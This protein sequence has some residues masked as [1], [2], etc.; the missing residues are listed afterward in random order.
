MRRQNFFILTASIFSS[1]QHLTW[2][3]RYLRDWP[4]SSLPA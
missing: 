2:R 1:N 4:G 3:C